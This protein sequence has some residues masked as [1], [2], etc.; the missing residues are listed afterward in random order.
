MIKNFYKIIKNTIRPYFYRLKLEPYF[1]IYKVN[2]ILVDMIYGKLEDISISIISKDLNN[3]ILN[4]YNK[5]QTSFV[6]SSEIKIKN[7]LISELTSEQFAKIDEITKLYETSYDFC[8]IINDNLADIIRKYCR[9]PYTIVNTRMWITSPGTEPYGPNAMHTDG[10]YPSHFKVMIYPFGLNSESGYLD[11]GSTAINDEPPGTVVLFRNSDIL[12]AGVAGTKKE[13]LVV[14]ITLLRTFFHLPQYHEGHPNGRHYKNLF[15]V[16]IKYIKT[17]GLINSI[18]KLVSKKLVKKIESFN[19][20]FVAAINSFI[21]CEK[22]NLGSGKKSWISWRC[23]DALTYPTIET[24]N[25]D[26]NTKLPE[27]VKDIRLFYSSH[28]LEHLDDKTATNLLKQV[29]E[30]L[31]IGGKFVIKMPDFEYLL[32][33]YRKNKLK[34]INDPGVLDT[35][36]TWPNRNIATTIEN[37]ISMV[38]C[39]YMSKSYG[40]HFVGD[41]LVSLS[42]YH[43]PCTIPNELLKDLLL[44]HS[45]RDISKTLNQYAISDSDFGQFNHQN[46]WSRKDLI[47]I[48]EKMGFGFMT[49][50]RERISKKYKFSIPDIKTSYNSSMYLEFIKN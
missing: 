20:K 41:R 12:H 3:Y 6:K 16:M 49:S 13:R 43:G 30:R 45:V 1:S 33:M 2:Q 18:L 36:Y 5:K 21:R 34:Q 15:I 25:F 22:I 29:H 38:F 23:F 37:K 8:R 27:N 42:P 11:L 40:N 26:K 24:L 48:L 28:N 39:G 35:M 14:E 10:F 17:F 9:S 47:E 50:D 19:L 31:R 46:A 32:E 7:L 44:N 4:S